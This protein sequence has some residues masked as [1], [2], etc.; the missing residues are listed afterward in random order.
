MTLELRYA[1][2]SDVGLLREGNEDSAYAGPRLLAV[3]DGMG[4]HAAGGVASNIVKQTLLK[5]D[6]PEAPGAAV[7]AAHAAVAAAAQANP[8][9][10]GMG[11]TVICAHVAGDACS[12]VW[13]GDSRG[14]LWRDGTLQR[15]TKDHSFAEILRS[16]QGLSD[17]EIRV[18][19]ARHVVTQTLGLGTPEPSV[20]ETRLRQGDWIVLCSD[21]LTD[22]L[23]DQGIMQVLAASPGAEGAANGLVETALNNGG[24]DNVSVVVLT[25]DDGS[26][27]RPR[28]RSSAVSILLSI[29]GGVG[30]ALVCAAAWYLFGR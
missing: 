23:T 15:L 13:V 6:V 27:R 18:H 14:Y 9:Y 22:E 3:A 29:A 7:L 16:E 4:G 17:N 5:P 11:S 20:V 10:H 8:E 24:H 19:P 21:G 12:L 30:V 1:V 28:E 25:Y 26:G 2:R